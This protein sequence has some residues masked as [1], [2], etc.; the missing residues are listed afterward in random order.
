[1]VF[2][3]Q[4]FIS[5]VVLS[6][7]SAVLHFQHAVGQVLVNGQ[8]FTNG[9]AIIDSPAPNSTLHAGSTTSV[10]IDISGDGRLAQ[11]ASIPGSGQS[12]RFDS[13]EVYLVS[14]ETSL[15]L[16]VSQGPTLLTQESGSTVK[17]INWLIDSCVASGNYNLTFYESSHIQDTAYFII[18]PL[19]I[20]IQNTNPTTSCSNGTNTLV[21]FPQ[22]SSAPTH[23][24][25]L[26]STQTSL[27]PFPSATSSG[28]SGTSNS[29]YTA[30][31]LALFLASA[32]LVLL[33][34][35]PGVTLLPFLL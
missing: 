18:T 32:S 7:L 5:I 26:D 17:H 29:R 6:F 4:S 35:S 11:S 21:S 20:E 22:P 16:T 14:Y 9:L 34:L 31:T 24:P 33:G 1:M 8:I 28:A 27:I 23:S 19:P 25:W 10:A 15:N 13:L 2:I 12:T 30:Q 3:P